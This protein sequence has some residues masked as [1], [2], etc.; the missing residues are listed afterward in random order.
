MAA[1]LRAVQRLRVLPAF[2]PSPVSAG[3]F[4]SG[5]GA[6]GSAERLLGIARS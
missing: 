1:A 6:V 3:G 4:G 2:G 5:C